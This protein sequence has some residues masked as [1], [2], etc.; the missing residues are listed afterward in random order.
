MTTPEEAEAAALKA[1]RYSG[2]LGGTDLG[3]ILALSDGIFAFAMTL[4]VIYVVPPQDLAHLSSDRAALLA[5]GIGFMVL[6]IWWAAHHR[7]FLHIRRWDRYLLWT[8]LVLLMTIA[9]QPFFINFWITFQDQAAPGP[10]YAGAA[11]AGCELV[12]A[13]LFALVW[14]EASYRKRL[15]HP[16]LADS[17]IRG[18][19]ERVLIAPFVFLAAI[20]IAF[21]APQ[22]TVVFFIVLAPVQ[23]LIGRVRRG[24]DPPSLPRAP[25]SGE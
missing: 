13:T 2:E 21:V 14:F 25:G 10:T 23:L 12:T 19:N 20:G 3:R 11:Y 24:P 22:Y 15:I 17:V 5:Y 9:V 7:I 1:A 18:T 8:N 16:E 6:G 4:L